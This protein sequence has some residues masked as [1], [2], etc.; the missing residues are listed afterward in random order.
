[1]VEF[2]AA[3]LLRPEGQLDA[4]WF[5]G[6][7]RP[8]V[9]QTLTGFAD[10]A[11]NMAGVIALDDT[12]VGGDDRQSPQYKAVEAYAYGHGF[13]WIA[14]DLSSRLGT[15]DIE[16]EVRKTTFPAGATHFQ[17]R[18]NSWLAIFYNLVPQSKPITLAKRASV[19]I[20]A[21]FRY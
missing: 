19:S 8:A 2:N 11:A 3:N 4:G 6:L 21:R 17:N 16:T 10:A 5:H 15:I 18:A 14:D 1:M 9:V 12:D 20:S 7:S 13:Q